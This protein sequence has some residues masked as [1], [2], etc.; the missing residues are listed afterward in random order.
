MI[1]RSA[2]DLLNEVGLDAFTTRRLA[3]R[4]GVKQPAIYWH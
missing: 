1:V 2:L 3:E 4:L